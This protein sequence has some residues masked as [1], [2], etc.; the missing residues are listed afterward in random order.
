MG[1][2][3]RRQLSIRQEGHDQVNTFSLS[4]KNIRINGFDNLSKRVSKVYPPI[5]KID[6][7]IL[8]TL[9][10]DI[11]RILSITNLRAKQQVW[12]SF[13]NEE[14]VESLEQKIFRGVIFPE[15]GVKIY[16]TRLDSP[17][18][19]ARLVG[20]AYWVSEK[21]IHDLFGRWGEVK[22]LER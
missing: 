22:S 2:P 17:T 9:G 15:S 16:G 18:V 20:A 11:K 6:S 3:T 10:L 1:F 19:H 14:D 8:D 4:F 13:V 7:F 12:I 21:D 5:N